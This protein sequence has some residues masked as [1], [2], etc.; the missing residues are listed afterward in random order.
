[1]P[2]IVMRKKDHGAIMKTRI[3]H[4]VTGTLQELSEISQ[5]YRYKKLIPIMQKA[6]LVGNGRIL[7]KEQGQAKERQKE[8]VL[9]NSLTA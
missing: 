8:N 9:M 6:F 5:I 7:R 1:M 2:R 4:V 3:V